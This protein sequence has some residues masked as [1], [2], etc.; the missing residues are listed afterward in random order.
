MSKQRRTFSA[1]F[2]RVAAATGISR[3]TARLAVRSARSKRPRPRN[4]PRLNI[5]SACTCFPA[6]QSAL[7]H[8]PAKNPFFWWAI[9]A[10]SGQNGPER[11]NRAKLAQH[12]V[13]NAAPFFWWAILA[14]DGPIGPIWPGTA[15][16][17]QIGPALRAQR[18]PI[19]L[20]GHFGPRWPNRANLARNG[21]IG[22]I[23]PS[24][25]CT[26]PPHPHHPHH[27]PFSAAADCTCI[28]LCSGPFERAC[29][30]LCS[31]EKPWQDY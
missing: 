24:T 5:R 7:P 10:Q 8:D 22:P 4:G 28:T 1:E 27:P 26:T 21:P 15:Q 11:P 20:V 6:C 25:P 18:R 2:K 19:L 23:W 14:Q 3:R 9:L 16:S 12:S 13:H 29:I 17:G 30:T 31:G